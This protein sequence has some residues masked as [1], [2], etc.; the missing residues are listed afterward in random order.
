MLSPASPLQKDVIPKIWLHCYSACH[1]QWKRR[2]LKFHVKT[3]EMSEPFPIHRRRS[4][5]HV[6]AGFCSALLGGCQISPSVGVLGAYFPDWM[7]CTIF[8]I[9]AAVL[10]DRA[11]QTVGW[12]RHAGHWTLITS[13]AALCISLA[14]LSW[15]LLFQN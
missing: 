8:A 14:L 7:F 2:L 1:F 4:L 3:S 12:R 13:Y 10:I 11:L 6:A 15:L 5:T 9:A